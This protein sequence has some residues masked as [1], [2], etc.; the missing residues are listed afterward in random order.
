MSARAGMSVFVRACDCDREHV[1][2]T[3]FY[4]AR[5]LGPRLESVDLSVVKAKKFCVLRDCMVSSREG[6]GLWAFPMAPK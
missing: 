6:S 1:R 3:F 2:W 4:K 5:D